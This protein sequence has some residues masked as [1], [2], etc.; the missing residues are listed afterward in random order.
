MTTVA[1]GTSNC[2]HRFFKFSQT[3][4]NTS[5]IITLGQILD[6][7]E[8]GAR[9]TDCCGP[10]KWDLRHSEAKSVCCNVSFLNLGGSTDPPTLPDLS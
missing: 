6:F 1:I 9:Y 4:T 10:R 8:G 3:F 7:R 2:F 5:V